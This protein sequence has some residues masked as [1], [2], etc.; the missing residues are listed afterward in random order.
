MKKQNLGR[1]FKL[2]PVQT[3]FVGNVI[4]FELVEPNCGLLI[5]MGI[6]WWNFFPSKVEITY[7]RRNLY[8]LHC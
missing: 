3:F 8:L 2:F 6:L 7:D 4:W 5:Y 1:S